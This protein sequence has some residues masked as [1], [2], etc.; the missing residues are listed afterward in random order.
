MPKVQVIR[1]MAVCYIFQD[2]FI[3]L[4]IHCQRVMHIGPYKGSVKLAKTSNQM[5][6]IFVQKYCIFLVF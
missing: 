5:Q 1:G 3:D 2:D 6:N 4:V